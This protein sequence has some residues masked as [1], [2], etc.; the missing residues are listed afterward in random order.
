ML[1]RS[2]I[3]IKAKQP[4]LDW[5]RT[6]PDPKD[7]ITLEEIDFDNTAYLLPEYEMNGQREEILAH[8]FDM[9]FEDQLK[10]WSRDSTD[11]PKKRDFSTFKKW[12]EVEFHS[13]VIDLVDLPLEYG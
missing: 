1:N 10:D 5:L 13:L 9:V 11:W 4:F 7:K 12:F 2:V 3:T 6:L 8:Y